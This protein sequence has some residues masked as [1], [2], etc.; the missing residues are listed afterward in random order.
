VNVTNGTSTGLTEQADVTAIGKTLGLKVVNI[1]AQSTSEGVANAFEQ[2]ATTPGVAGVIEGAF[3]PSQWQSTYDSLISKHIPV[4]MYAVTCGPWN[5]TGI[6][7]WSS[8]GAVSKVSEAAAQW[9][10]AD[11]NGHPN[12]VVV[13]VPSSPILVSVTTAFTNE[14]KQ[15]CPSCSL[16]TLDVTN[17]PAALGTTLPGTVASYLEGHPDVKY[18]FT[19]FGDMLTG[20][21]AAAKASGI[22]G[23][24]FLSEDA[25]QDDIPN[26][27]QGTEAA[28]F[29]EPHQVVDYV[30]IDAVARGILGQSTSA[31]SAWLMPFNLLTP[32]TVGQYVSSGQVDPKSGHY[33]VPNVA[34]YFASLWKTQ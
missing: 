18:V 3:D 14:Y 10:Y 8:C 33:V 17:F 30:A 23:V 32:A 21:P 7:I 31:A 22:S 28:Q 13:A 15:L 6:V 5:S 12:A 27:E 24:K 26:L 2:A 20:I 34:A 4:V 1:V 9:V 25:N 11:A 29:T 19:D 16:D